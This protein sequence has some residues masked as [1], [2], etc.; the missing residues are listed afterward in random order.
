MSCLF[1][2]NYIIRR[3]III[4]KYKY[5]DKG[6]FITSKLV[7]HINRNNRTNSWDKDE[8][9]VL[10][11]FLEMIGNSSSILDAGCGDGRLISKYE[12]HFKEITAVEKDS[13]RLEGAI[14]LVDRLNLGSKV[15]LQLG[16]IQDLKEDKKFD[17]IICSHVLQHI[18]TMDCENVVKKFSK[19]INP[20][21]LLLILVSHSGIAQD[22]FTKLN[23]IREQVISVNEFNNLTEV[24]R[25][26][27]VRKFAKESIQTLVTEYGFRVLQCD[28]YHRLEREVS[29]NKNNRRRQ[30]NKP[31]YINVDLYLI[32]EKI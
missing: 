2:I 18:S 30:K 13:S 24:S 28:V 4:T 9:Q 20:G 26:L 15:S 8:N 3:L 22:V 21:G 17:T 6:D 31:Q 7:N 12:S 23:H 32:A 11:S 27:P 1:L 10:K 14:N 25:S 19:I 29:F 5:Q 16:K